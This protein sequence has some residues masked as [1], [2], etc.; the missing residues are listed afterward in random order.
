M[1]NAELHS[2]CERIARLEQQRKE[3]AAEI[4]A[5]KKDAKD[6]GFD[7][8]LITK[9]VRVML[10]GPKKRQETLE[11]HELFDTYLAAAGLLPSFEANVDERETVKATATR[12]RMEDTARQSQEL[13]DAGLISQE[14][15]EETRRIAE[16]IN[17][18]WG[19]G[20]PV[21][22]TAEPK[23]WAAP[24]MAAAIPAHDAETG[25]IIEPPSASPAAEQA[26]AELPNVPPTLAA[27]AV[28]SQPDPDITLP[29][30]LNRKKRRELEAAE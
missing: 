21:A 13:A 17:R 10:M 1:S 19:D 27:P 20:K 26:G 7:A 2:T 8:A 6:K 18:K 30:F 9:T 25:E 16:A 5:I 12:Y 24:E 3:L 28:Y 29:D 23:L 14:N 11:Q 15:A 22:T 4:S